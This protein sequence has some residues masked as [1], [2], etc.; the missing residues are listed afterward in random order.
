MVAQPVPEPLWA[1]RRKPHTSISAVKEYLMCPRRYFFHY[2]EEA[3][4]A[5][6]AAASAFGSAWHAVIQ[7]WLTSESVPQEE[8]ETYFRD[9]LAAR[10]QDG[11]MPVL[12]DDDETEGKLADTGIKM[13]RVF[14]ARVA[15]PEVVVGVEVPF[16]MSLTHPTTGEV[17]GVP[18]VGAV[19]ALV[20]SDGQKVVVELKTSKRRWSTDQLEYDLQLSLY[21]KAAWHLGYADAALRLLVTTKAVHPDVQAE[22]VV[23]HDADIAEVVDVIFGVH[24]AAA[25]GVDYRTRGWQCNGCPYSE[26]CRP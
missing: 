16:S 1:L 17:L 4:P 26:R 14:V 19:D 7:H 8:L 21:K 11:R 24:A 20:V 25:A 15:R 9:D 22:D 3:Q 18:V 23:R 6:R 10:L 13:L 2:V 12:F 5:F